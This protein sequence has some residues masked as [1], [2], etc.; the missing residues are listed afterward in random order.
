MGD[1]I[2]I[3]G[4]TLNVEGLGAASVALADNGVPVGGIIM[5]SGL[6]VDI[7]LGWQL[8]DGTVPTPDL[9]D[10]FIV[11]AAAGIDPGVTG[12]STT[13]THADHGTHSNQGAHQHDSL[14]GHTHDDHS[15]TPPSDH[16][17]HTHT[18]PSHQHAVTGVTVAGEAAHSHAHTHDS[19]GET[20]LGALTGADTLLISPTTHSSDATAG[21]SHTHS[22][23]GSVDAGGT[24]ATGNES[25]ALSHNGS[26]SPVT[27]SSGGDHL[28]S[29][30][31]GHTHDA[32]TVHSTVD[33]RPSFYSLA[34]LMKV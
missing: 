30:D 28:H 24:G 10:R 3:N 33:S 27:H 26:V 21:T 13:H 19:H 34:F 17:S 14:G 7:P 25:A 2:R 18:G 12:G 9:R 6:L 20:N 15:F 22:L 4:I 1:L 32:H 11:G 8:C 29:S 16:A 23:G 31:G 5:W